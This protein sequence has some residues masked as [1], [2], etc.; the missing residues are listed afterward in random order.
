MPPKNLRRLRTR[1]RWRDLP[2]AFAGLSVLLALLTVLPTVLVAATSRYA[3]PGLADLSSF[4]QLFTRQDNGS[5][6]LFVLVVIGWIGWGSFA[7]SVLL[8]IPAQ[9][10]GRAAPRLRGFGWSQQIAS[11]LVSA[12]LLL[13]PATG[14]ALAASAA[15]ATAATASAVAGYTATADSTQAQASQHPTYT[16]RSTSPAQSLWS[17]AQDQLGS[18]DRWQQIA[19]LNE[20]RTMAGGRVFHADRPIQP[21]WVLLMPGVPA[22][23][24]APA[25]PVPGDSTTTVTVHRG[26]TLSA[27]AEEHLGSADRYQQLFDANRDR[28]EPG[29]AHLTDPDHIEPG[30]TLALPADTAAAPSTGSKP[31]TPPTG[32]GTPGDQ[33]GSNSGSGNQ[34]PTTAPTTTPPTAAPTADAAG[35]TA[36]AQ[37]S[38]HAAAGPEHNQAASADSG[39]T[40]RHLAAGGAIL[41][42][43]VLASIGFRRRLQQRRR[44][45]TRRIPMPAGD[46]AGLERQLRATTNP[47]GLTLLDR[48]LRSMAARAADLGREVPQLEAVRVTGDTVE[49]YLAAPTAPIPP[50]TTADGE[51]ALWR[52]SSSTRNTALATAEEA[53]R[54]PAPYPTLVSLGHTP[55]GDPVLVDLETMGL[56]CLDGS[57]DDVLAV[58]RAFTVE[59]ANSK[60]ADDR[61]LLLA[62]IGQELAELYPTHSDYYETLPDALAT[63]AARDAFQRQAL[64]DGGHCSLRAARV[65]DPGAG[66]AWTPHILISTD[67]PAAPQA[68]QLADL[69]GAQ[70]RTSIGVIAG[71]RT[72]LPVETSWRI[73]AEAGLEIEVEGLPF[74]VV[75]QR[76]EPEAYQR[77]VDVLA[78]AERRDTLPAPAWTHPAPHTVPIEEAQEQGIEEEAQ[79]AVPAGAGSAL[80]AQVIHTATSP[81][82]GLGPAALP[83]AATVPVALA[84]TTAGSAPAGPRPAQPSGASDADLQ[85]LGL[86]AE[87]DE[88]EQDA[89]PTGEDP[90]RGK[91]PQPATDTTGPEEDDDPGDDADPDEDI[92]G[93]GSHGEDEHGWDEEADEDLDALI[94]R[95]A[96]AADDDAPAEKP[97]LP[98][99]AQEP[100][101]PALP[102]A[103]ASHPADTETED[104][105]ADDAGAQ[106]AAVTAAVPSP[107][108]AG[109]DARISHRLHNSSAVLAA[110]TAQ[111]GE[112]DAPY[113]RL[114]GRVEVVGLRSAKQEE[115]RRQLTEVT[116]W[117]VLHPGSSRTEF[118]EAMWKGTRVNNQARNTLM[119]RT[120]RWLGDKPDGSPYLPHITEDV[121][122]IDPAV[123]CDWA[124]FQELYRTGYHGS[125]LEAD[126]ALAQ[127]LALVRGRPFAGT[128]STRYHW[129]EA[130]VQEMISAVEDAAHELAQRRLA[131]RDYRAAA[132]AAARGL[133]AIPESELLYRDLFEI[134]AASGD[135]ESLE[136]AARRL[137]DLNEE[138]NVD[139]EEETVELLQALLKGCR[140]ATA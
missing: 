139:P 27:I 108:P 129:S 103:R 111:A 80:A 45:P 48:S 105:E 38:P 83:G 72:D 107:A 137:H 133:E 88:Q 119:S 7:L 23:T 78:T 71:S 39:D 131:E 115:R 74:T 117:L 124:Q 56:L 60:I 81:A 90:V 53:A 98:P 92:F 40:V 110:L 9:L 79:E 112:P 66:D 125:G 136:R 62:G 96:Q 101:T 43:G 86:V 17:I 29:G 2:Q 73:P 122:G 21:G 54:I 121:Y 120:R 31:T 127:A 15:P 99:A 87:K 55:D 13:V 32:P 35:S 30:W 42:A 14:A 52:C 126:V 20:G 93:L 106:P 51:S 59:L 102:A 44:Q 68:Q 97:A 3:G 70:P 128:L 25:T 22:A 5:A 130:W 11:A 41:A 69:L 33:G 114:L 57:D 1:S 104:D 85:D 10:R 91:S 82:A 84:K 6:F 8:E 26:D 89:R 16:V 63:L 36:A 64:D 28:P 134:H 138:L 49:L 116:A 94:A 46:S 140:T 109:P 37:P 135:R 4:T 18:G 47:T 61:L 12:I 58:L 34:S 75:L 19:A 95:Y 76:I 65:S 50:F 67:E 100:G 77:L 24:T 132:M 113:V 123:T 118:D